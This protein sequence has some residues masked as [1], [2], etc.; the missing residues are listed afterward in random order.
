MSEIL[1]LRGAPAFSSSRLVRLND[2][3]KSALPRLK[4]LAAEHWYFAEVSAPL[5]VDEMARLADLL[6]AH[7]EGDLPAGS[8]LVVTPRRA[9]VFLDEA[10]GI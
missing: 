5:D 4:G 9:K 1:K 3:V 2:A 7:P 8:M 10:A 6:G